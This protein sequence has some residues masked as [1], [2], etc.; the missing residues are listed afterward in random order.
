MHSQKESVPLNSAPNEATTSIGLKVMMVRRDLTGNTELLKNESSVEVERWE[1]R[2]AQPRGQVGVDSA[3]RA[4]CWSLVFASEF[5]PEVGDTSGGY[6][7]PLRI[8][9]CIP[10]RRA[11]N[12]QVVRG[13]SRAAIER[14][15]FAKSATLL[16]SRRACRCALL[17]TSACLARH[18]HQEKTD[19]DFNLLCRVDLGCGGAGDAGSRRECSR[20]VRELGL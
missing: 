5:V 12:G 13:I 14:D 9:L 10:M 11:S 6:G 1:A 18:L 4:T 17:P 2:G 20:L 7:I 19:E 8:P 3:R 15:F 16:D